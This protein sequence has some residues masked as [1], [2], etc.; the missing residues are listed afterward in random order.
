MISKTKMP[1]VAYYLL[2]LWVKDFALSSLLARYADA[3][4]SSICLALSAFGAETTKRATTRDYD[5]RNITDMFDVAYDTYGRDRFSFK[6]CHRCLLDIQ[7]RSYPQYFLLPQ[8]LMVLTFSHFKFT[9]NATKTDGTTNSHFYEECH[10][11]YEAPL[12]RP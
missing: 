1:D 4:V 9:R 3:L 10:Q 11:N 12:R 5:G 6:A 7:M 8:H 2:P